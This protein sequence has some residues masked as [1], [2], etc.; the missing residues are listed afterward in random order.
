MIHAAGGCGK[1]FVSKQLKNVLFTATTG[2]AAKILSG[3]TI[4]S[5]LTKYGS[6]KNNK[7]FVNDFGNK[8]HILIDECSMISSVKLIQIWEFCTI[9]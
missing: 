4:D 2:T 8:S 6:C 3:Y 1:T 5:I 7:R 9:L